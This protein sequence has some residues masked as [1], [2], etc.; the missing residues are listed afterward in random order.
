M[1][2][3][4]AVENVER[5]VMMLEKGIATKAARHRYYRALGYLKTNAN[6]MKYGNYDA[7]GKREDEYKQYE[8]EHGA[9]ITPISQVLRRANNGNPQ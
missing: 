7:W 4:T 8:A 9:D 2:T 5:Y 1:S 3:Y 6:Y